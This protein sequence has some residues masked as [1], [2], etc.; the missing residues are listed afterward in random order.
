MVCHECGNVE[1]LADVRIQ[2]AV[3][4]LL[5]RVSLRSPECELVVYGLCERCSP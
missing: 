3:R 2:R 1:P 5:R 4:G